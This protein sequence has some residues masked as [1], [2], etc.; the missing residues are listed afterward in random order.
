MLLDFLRAQHECHVADRYY[1]AKDEVAG[2]AA[3]R[4][5]AAIL[6]RQ[7]H[8]LTGFHSRLTDENHAWVCSLLRRGKAAAEALRLAEQWNQ[9]LSERVRAGR[10]RPDLWDKLSQS[11][12]QIAKARWLLNQ[13]E[14]TLEAYHQALMAQRQMCVLAPHVASSR[15]GLGLIHLVLGRKLCELG[16]LDE[17]EACL[18]ERQALWPGDVSKHEEVLRELRKWA[19]QAEEEYDQLTPEQQK[20][21]QRYRDLR[22]RLERKGPGVELASGGVKP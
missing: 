18:Q 7:G 10:E 14:E 13:R 2:L 8:P 21:P 5:A 6:E 1:Q 20:Y 19:R 15:V 16:R 22:E 17:A 12:L 3:A 9:S 11:W 4:N